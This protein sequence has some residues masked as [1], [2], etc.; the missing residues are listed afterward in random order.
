[1]KLEALPQVLVRG[2]FSVNVELAYYDG[3]GQGPALLAVLGGPCWASPARGRGL[4]VLTFDVEVDSSSARQ[5]VS[6][7]SAVVRSRV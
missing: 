2:R 1:M 7:L 3:S 6:K 5:G 4:I